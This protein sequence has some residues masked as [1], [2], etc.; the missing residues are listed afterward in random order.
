MQAA[1]QAIGYTRVSTEDQKRK[2][3]SLPAQRQ[4]VEDYCGRT[5]L[6]LIG[7][8]TDPGISGG[9]SEQ[10]RP[11]LEAVLRCIQ[12]GEAQALVTHDLD[13]LARDESLAYRVRDMV[14]EHDVQL[15]FTE[16]GLLDF[17]S[18]MGHYFFSGKAQFAAMYRRDIGRKVRTRR[19]QHAHDGKSWGRAPIGYR[20]AEGALVIVD[21]EATAVKAAYDMLIDKGL[22]RSQIALRLNAYPVRA[23]E[24][25]GW[26]AHSVRRLLENPTHMG[27]LRHKGKIYKGA[28]TAII[29]PERWH[30]AQ[31]LLPERSTSRS[32]QQG[33]FLLSG[34]LKCP[35]CQS[36]MGGVWHPRKRS[37]SYKC[38][39]RSWHPPCTAMIGGQRIMGMLTDAL[40]DLSR[41]DDRRFDILPV[42]PPDT[43]LHEMLGKRL[44]AI[45]EE[46]Q[47]C[48]RLARKDLMSDDDLA[49]NLAELATEATQIEEQLSDAPILDPTVTRERIVGVLGALQSTELTPERKR[50]LLRS[51]ISW[52]SWS[53]DGLHFRLAR[54]P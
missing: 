8:E 34:I 20:R 30:R 50:V 33:A 18:E 4:L 13:R 49:E 40:G 51:L 16:T 45:P 52:A 27:H 47:R 36:G 46:R 22:S 31:Q 38:N 3:I 29:T 9:K 6:C 7:V 19:L 43:R 54:L 14:I 48:Y 39:Q 25:Q 53:D 42:D 11:G 1:M 12:A 32:P 26:R 24:R 15:H 5:G 10:Y 21:D 44:A 17:D 41:A 28:H 2:D 37:H 23:P 35:R